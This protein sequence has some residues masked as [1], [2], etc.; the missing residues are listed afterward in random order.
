[1]TGNALLCG[2]T[3]VE[4]GI[5]VDPGIGPLRVVRFE[6][7]EGGLLAGEIAVTLMLPVPGVDERDVAFEKGAG[8]PENLL[9]RTLPV[10]PVGAV[11][12]E[13]LPVGYGVDMGDDGLAELV[14]LVEE[15]IVPEGNPI[16]LL[17]LAA[18]G[19]GEVEGIAEILLVTSA[20]VTS[21]MLSVGLDAGV[22]E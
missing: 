16:R 1:M 22:E 2:T 18:E 15:L 12:I 9:A 13:K 6:V 7:G 4:C 5:P 21:G 3:P 8:V 17:V 20:D 14:L 19:E 11:E 10:T